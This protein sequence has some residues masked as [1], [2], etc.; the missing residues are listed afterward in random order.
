MSFDLQWDD[1]GLVPAIVQHASS[2]EV[3]MLAYMN[4]DS[5][6][7]TIQS[8]ETWFW[9]RSRQALWHKGAT[10]GNRQQVLEILY[11]CDGDAL[12]VRVK[13]LGPA[14]HTG[15]PSCFFS[16]AFESPQPTRSYHSVGSV[17]QQLSDTI[18]D[19][20]TNPRSG[21]YTAQLLREGETE[22]LKKVGEEAIEVLL[23]ATSENE[24]RL[25]S[26]LADLT[27]HVFVLLAE[28][29][30]SYQDVVQELDRRA[31]ESS[32]RREETPSAD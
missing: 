9:S 8:G 15:K 6:D 23:A 20:R 19:R 32:P 3:L 28:K 31:R 2:G 18:A 21:S 12:L 25:V 22:I 4:R 24:Q 16:R 7:R 14:C 29:G 11:D 1:R 26:E 13:P 5:L 10:S 30:L 17:L 27:Y